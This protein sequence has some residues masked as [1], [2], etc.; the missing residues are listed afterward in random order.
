MVGLLVICDH[1]SYLV[2]SQN[3]IFCNLPNVLA[4]FN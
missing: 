2:H 3:T 4:S 1:L